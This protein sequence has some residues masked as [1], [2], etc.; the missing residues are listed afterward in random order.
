MNRLATFVLSLVQVGGTIFLGWWLATNGTSGAWWYTTAQ[1]VGVGGIGVA[2]AILAQGLFNKAWFQPGTFWTIVELLLATAG[3]I[4]IFSG[5]F[6]FA[7]TM[8]LV[9]ATGFLLGFGIPEVEEFIT[10]SV[11]AKAKA[12]AAGFAGG[13]GRTL[14]ANMLKLAIAWA[15]GYGLSVAF[16]PMT[17]GWLYW[18][19]IGIGILGLALSLS[20]PINA[21]IALAR[22]HQGQTWGTIVTEVTVCAI[23]AYCFFCNM[24]SPTP[25]HIVLVGGM[26]IVLV[27]QYLRD[28]SI[29]GTVGAIAG[30]VWRIIAWVIGLLTSPLRWI[31][32]LGI[33]LLIILAYFGLW[34]C[35]AKSGTVMQCPDFFEKRKYLFRE[36]GISYGVICAI[37]DRSWER[38]SVGLFQVPTPVLTSFGV[39]WSPT[40]EP[41]V[42]T[43]HNVG[44]L[45][46]VQSTIAGSWKNPAI[47]VAYSAWS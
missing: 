11:W 43:H 40:K 12:G 47:V 7:N 38:R 15:T 14:L 16:G 26:T 22:G 24:V 36:K 37:V 42:L 2:L 45:I 13:R 27:I 35:W 29:F 46:N 18:L 41:L 4:S 23:G 30:C 28:V 1:F 44:V 19:V 39:T 5:F 25:I 3:G 8:H 9:I 6:Q 33:I 17:A 10:T 20:L 32:G 34:G 21:M 31:L